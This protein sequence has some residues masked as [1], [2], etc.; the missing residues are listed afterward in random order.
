MYKTTILLTSLLCLLTIS[1]ASQQVWCSSNLPCYSKY[2]GLYYLTLT[3]GNYTWYMQ[4]TLRLDSSET[5]TGSDQVGVEQPEATDSFFQPYSNGNGKWT[6]DRKVQIKDYG[7]VYPT[8]KLPT[9]NF[10]YNNNFYL[11]LNNARHITGTFQYRTYNLNTTYLDET[12]RNSNIKHSYLKKEQVGDVVNYNVT[13][14]QIDRFCENI[15]K[16]RE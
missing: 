2:A 4:L 8:A 13:G 9:S 12:A 15:Q 1:R 10:I 7:F 16:V 3:N 6:C 11:N 14:Y 5:W